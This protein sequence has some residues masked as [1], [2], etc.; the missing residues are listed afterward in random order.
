MIIII[1]GASHT[2]KTVL[3]QKLLEKYRYPYLSLDHLKMGLIRSVMTSLTP[4]D[5]DKLTPYLW[6]I[7]KEIIKTAIENRQNLIIEG[8]YVPHDW[9]DYFTDDYLEH[10][11]AVWL[12]MTRHY[13]TSHYTDIMEHA[14]DIEAR[15]DDDFPME[16]MIAENEWYYEQCVKNKCDYILID[17]EYDVDY[18]I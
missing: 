1:S 14:S 15:Q 7:T 5:D 9:A 11:R 17:G 4:Y 18:N 3:A 10:I 13:I 6:N 12:I 8:C 2:G 16:D